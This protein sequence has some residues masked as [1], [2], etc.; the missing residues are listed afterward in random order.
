MCFIEDKCFFHLLQERFHCATDSYLGDIYD[1]EAY[2]AFPEDFG[3]SPTKSNQI[4]H[5]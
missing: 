1:D 4:I 3:A 2:R 5:Q